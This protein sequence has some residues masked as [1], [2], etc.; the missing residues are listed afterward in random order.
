MKQSILTLIQKSKE[1]NFLKEFFGFG[2]LFLILLLIVALFIAPDVIN[3]S[4]YGLIS[5]FIFFTMWLISISIKILMYTVDF[6]KEIQ[7]GNIAAAILVG[8]VIIVIG[9][10]TDSFIRGI[11]TYYMK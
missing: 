5:I 2:T 8:A 9:L 1:W 7:K 11:Y 4:M 6:P 3:I 10:I